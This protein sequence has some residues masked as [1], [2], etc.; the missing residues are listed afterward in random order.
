MN[1]EFQVFLLPLLVFVLSIMYKI[2]V[3]HICILCRFYHPAPPETIIFIETTDRLQPTLLVMCAVESAARTYPNWTINFYMKGLRKDMVP[4]ETQHQA[5]SHLSTMKNV[6]LLPLN[7]TLI[8]NG[9]PLSSWYE[10]VSPEKEKYWTHVSSD[11]CRLALVWRYGGIYMDSDFISM[12]PIPHKTFLAAQSSKVSSNGILGFHDHHQFLW[13]C[14]VD[15]AQHYNGAIWG[16]QGPSLITRM[17]AKL[18]MLPTFE[19]SQDDVCQNISFLHPNRFYPIPYPAWR[20]F[21]EVWKVKP[22][23]DTA[24][25]LHLWNFMNQE[26]KQVVAGSNTLVEN[27]FKEYCPMT[28]KNMVVGDNLEPG[29]K[30]SR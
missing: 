7:M 21:F 18:C 24:Y 15:F 4:N 17:L 29:G 28:Y 23:F 2:N 25:A 16:H 22:T 20:K 30:K 9:T 19:N 13:D 3:G 27:L 14:M 1:K 10:K 8:L 12:R 6:F 26:K 5:L 11:A